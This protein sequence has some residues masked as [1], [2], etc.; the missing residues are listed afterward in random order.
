MNT[1][2][3]NSK[4]NANL[5]EEEL[6]QGRAADLSSPSECRRTFL[7]GA[8]AIPVI[9]TL[10]TGV[11][12]AMSSMQVCTAKSQQRVAA[13]QVAWITPE[14][15]DTWVRKAVTARRIQTVGPFG[16]TGTPFVVYRLDPSLDPNTAFT[17]TAF[18]AYQPGLSTDN[19]LD[20]EGEHYSTIQGDAQKNFGQ[21]TGL[22]A[23]TT[24]AASEP[25]HAESQM[26]SSRS[27]SLRVWTPDSSK[28][29]GA[30]PVGA[31]ISTMGVR[32]NPMDTMGTEASPMGAGSSTNRS[33]SLRVLTADA[34]SGKESEDREEEP[35][36]RGKEPG[37]GKMSDRAGN[38]YSIVEGDSTWYVLAQVN[39]RGQ[40]VGYGPSNSMGSS[41]I[42]GSCWASVGAVTGFG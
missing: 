39:D 4:R 30:N 25:I 35:E 2:Q 15:T 41:P 12:A 7:K 1:S 34:D 10:P 22:Q 37:L 38:T 31:G 36:D 8:A 29:G 20:Q 40:I 42:T 17:A 21:N 5:L 33:S 11:A 9:M 19:W 3:D 23:G 28:G 13:A 14:S 27:S 26:V 16:V 32:T 6:T 18:A 24:Q